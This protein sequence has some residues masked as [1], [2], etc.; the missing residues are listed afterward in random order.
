MVE[1]ITKLE[2]NT[3]SKHFGDVR[4]VDGID[5]TVATGESVVLLGPS[6]CGKTT[7]LRSVAGFIQPDGGEILLDGNV[8]ATATNMLPPEKRNLG[9]VFQNYAVWPHRTVFQNVSYALVIQKR[10]KREITER[11]HRALDLV[12][13][14]GLQ[15]RYPGELS[16]GQQQRVALARA[17]VAEPSMLLLDEPLSNLDAGLR[18]EMRFELKELQQRISMTTLYVT[19][20]QEEALVLADRI[21][22]MSAGKIEQV[23][24]PTEIYLHPATQ[25]VAD[26]VGI[27]N[28]VQGK[29]EDT[30]AAGGRIRISQEYGEPFWARGPDHLVSRLAKGADVAVSVRPEAI[31]VNGA[32]NGDNPPI[33]ARVKASAFLGNRFDLRLDIKGREFRCQVPQMDFGENVKVNFNS[34]LAWVIE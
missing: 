2:L 25:F 31:R 11:V 29:V 20:D 17:I 7:T 30:D 24:S 23:A 10:P 34:D 13:L 5:L 28:I 14:T 1:G 26:F 16:G 9:M 8:I 3:L 33:E 4:A 18:E 19:H 21:V 15:E 22:V 12:Q 6:G 27:N 32:V